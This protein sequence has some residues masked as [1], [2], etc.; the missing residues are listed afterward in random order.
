MY[1]EK[2]C[3]IAGNERG[4]EAADRTNLHLNIVEACC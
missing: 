4:N 1:R 2:D 3:S